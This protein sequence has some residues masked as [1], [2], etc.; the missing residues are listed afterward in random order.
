[1]KS[2]DR[3]NFIFN[4]IK[5][6]DILD[7]GGCQFGKTRKFIKESCKSYTGID[8]DLCNDKDI[9]Q[10]DAQHFNIE[11]KFDLILEGEVIEHLSNFQGFFESCK[12]HLK[13]NGELIITTPN[14]YSFS[15]IFSKLRHEEV[16]NTLKH[17]VLF[18]GFVFRSMAK[19]NGFIVREKLFYNMD[20]PK[21]L[22]LKLGRIIGKLFPKY[23]Y[24]YI[25][26]LEVEK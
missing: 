12:N 19:M 16:H 2:V 4:Y 20:N 8:I 23:A 26:I 11:K 7:I 13:E 24:G 9:I 21:T 6:K 22:S 18:D 15:A 25:F 17:T 3:L 10:A 14:P 5:S 1:M